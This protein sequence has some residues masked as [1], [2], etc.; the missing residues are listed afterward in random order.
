M[1]LCPP[2]E[3]PPRVLMDAL[4]RRGVEALLTGDAF[5]AALLLARVLRE[6]GQAGAPPALILIE[7]SRHRPAALEDLLRVARRRWPGVA[8]WRYDAAARPPL[9]AMAAGAAFSD[10]DASQRGRT[11]GAPEVVVSPRAGRRP[12]PELRLTEDVAPRRDEDD[13]PAQAPSALLSEEE[14]AM[15]LSDDFDGS[16]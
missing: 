1:A 7:P 8:L 4:T 11:N 16:R 2:G 10:H 9:R 6:S 14:L 13:Q 5:E 12:S 15:L 3:A